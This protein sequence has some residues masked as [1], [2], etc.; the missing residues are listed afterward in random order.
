MV[1]TVIAQP[2]K[3]RPHNSDR[4]NLAAAQPLRR[5]SHRPAQL[6]SRIGMLAGWRSRNR[7]RVAA[8]PRFRVPA[9]ARLR[10][11]ASARLRA[12]HSKQQ[13]RRTFFDFPNA[14]HRRHLLRLEFQRVRA[15][16]FAHPAPSHD[17][18][19]S[20]ACCMPGRAL[21]WRHGGC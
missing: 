20:G 13:R 8:L 5:H 10:A 12:R 19:R 16:Y 4:G 21:L 6:N 2:E 14:F 3:L 17:P 15:V 9:F 1:G 11:Y 18:H 7:C